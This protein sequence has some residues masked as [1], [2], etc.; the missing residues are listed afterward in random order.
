MQL[1]RPQTARS[2]SHSCTFWQRTKSHKNAGTNRMVREWVNWGIN[3]CR[4]RTP[5]LLLTSPRLVIRFRLVIGIM[6]HIVTISNCCG[7]SKRHR[8]IHKPGRSDLRKTRS[9]WQLCHLKSRIHATHVIHSHY[10]HLSN[11]STGLNQEGHRSEIRQNDLDLIAAICVHKIV[12]Q[13]S[14]L[15]YIATRPLN[16]IMDAY[17]SSSKRRQ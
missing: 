10:W 1:S 4:L 17:L 2:R 13:N 14:G 11:T 12:G 7:S 3:A 9:A 15:I 5:R 16:A 8:G 6:I